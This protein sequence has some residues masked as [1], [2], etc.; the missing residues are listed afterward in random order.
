M[1]LA[2]DEDHSVAAIVLEDVKF[3]WQRQGGFSL[4]VDHLVIQSGERVLLAGPSGTGKS[5]LL[6]LLAGI[7]QPRSGLVRIAG[8]D[9]TK[10]SARRRDR[11]RAEN[12]GLIFQ[13]FNLVPYLSC[14]D[15][16]MLPLHFAP[17][18]MRK[19]GGKSGALT[20]ARALLD[21]IGLEAAT[22]GDQPAGRLSVGQQQR[23]AVLRAL[24]G[25]PG[26]IIADEPTSALDR[27]H[28]EAFVA[29]LTEEIARAGAT[30]LMVSHDLSL[31]PLFDRT[32][33]L[34]DIATAERAS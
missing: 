14:L 4:A 32:I 3:A 16:I 28:Q 30:L 18:R 17:R 22:Y 23:V 29:I 13:S 24:V 2:N 21:G 25:T 6:S 34:S 7:V 8:E 26:L 11:F 20:Q 10:M 15:N 12:I 31:A 9:I 27:A 33:A 5:T 1:Q 19:V